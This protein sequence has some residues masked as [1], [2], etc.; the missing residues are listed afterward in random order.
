M[1]SQSPLPLLRHLWVPRGP[2]RLKGVH[3]KGPFWWM[4]MC[5]G[6]HLTSREWLMTVLNG[7]AAL[8]ELSLPTPRSICFSTLTLPAIYS[9]FLF[10][11]TSS[12]HEWYTSL[13]SMRR[14]PLSQESGCWSQHPW[15]TCWPWNARSWE[16]K[17]RGCFSDSWFLPA[18]C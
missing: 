12:R 7:T 9:C 4:S 17:T 13:A 1:S 5:C 14:R 10:P 11:I 18:S 3:I 15:L 8:S 16:R 2:C 6:R